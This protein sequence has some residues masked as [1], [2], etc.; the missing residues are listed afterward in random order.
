MKKFELDEKVFGG[1][2]LGDLGRRRCFDGEFGAG[3]GEC[4]Q[5]NDDQWQAATAAWIHFGDSNRGRNGDRRDLYG[6]QSPCHGC[7]EACACQAA[8]PADVALGRASS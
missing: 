4:G 2:E 5:A 8:G 7:F 1:G 6:V 3:D